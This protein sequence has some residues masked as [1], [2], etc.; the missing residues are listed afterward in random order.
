MHVQQLDE[1]DGQAGL[2]RGLADHGVARVLAMV[3]GAA[4]QRPD[5]GGTGSSRV[6]DQEYLVVG[7]PAERVGGDPPEGLQ[8]GGHGGIVPSLRAPTNCRVSDRITQGRHSGTSQGWYPG[9]HRG[10]GGIRT[11]TVKA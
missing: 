5:S 7:V 4:G 8:R 6:P 9:G 2:G 1:G 11:V 10:G 3:D